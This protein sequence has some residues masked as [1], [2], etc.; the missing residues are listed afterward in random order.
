MKITDVTATLFEWKD[1]PA[2]SYGGRNGP[3]EPSELALVE[4]H[5]DE[6]LVGRSLLGSSIRSAR[7]DIDSLTRSVRPAL[8]GADPLSIEACW[9]RLRKTY[10]ATT[11][12]VLGTVD[13]A[14]WDIHGQAAGLP[15]SVL[16]GGARQKIRAYAS[17]PTYGDVDAYLR[18]FDAIAAKG[19]IA[20]KIHPPADAALCI[21]ICR[22]LRQH[23]GPGFPLMLDASSLF[24]VYDARRIVTAIQDLAFEWIED[25]IS[26]HDLHNYARLREGNVIPLMATEYSEG[27]LSGFVPWLT[28]RATDYLR[29]DALVKGG[30]TGLLKA[31]HLAEA[32][33]LNLE[34]HHGGN[35]AINVAQLHLACGIVNTGW[36]EVLLPAEAQ[37]LAVLNDIHIEADGTVAPPTGPGHGIAFDTAYIRRHAT[38]NT[39]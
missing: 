16:F 22:A 6:G 9:A 38:A 20:Y 17:S 13:V 19:Y 15:L 7:L 11:N 12:R 14:L 23:A 10:R 33:G 29:G 3:G 26:E 31:A 37:Q 32:F 28:E 4:I 5:T 21:E 30:L 1:V 27:G 18:E 24:D 36:F 34:I 39:P 25:P 2:V 35:S 8:I